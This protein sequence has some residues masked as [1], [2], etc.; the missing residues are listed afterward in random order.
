MEPLERVTYKLPSA[1]RRL[2]PG[3]REA[4]GKSGVVFRFAAE[5]GVHRRSR[6]ATLPEQTCD[7]LP[8]RPRRPYPPDYSAATPSMPGGL[9]AHV[10]VYSLESGH[11]G[12][13]RKTGFSERRTFTVTGEGAHSLRTS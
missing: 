10:R 6:R 3:S 8:R 7:R 2:S 9:D 4:E 12:L 5:G 1:R 11:Q 13:G